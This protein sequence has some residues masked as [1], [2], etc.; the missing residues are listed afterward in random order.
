MIT[1]FEELI[2]AKWQDRFFAWLIDFVMVSVVVGIFSV[3]AHQFNYFMQAEWY[4]GTSAIFFVYWLIL[5]YSSGRSL[6]KRLMHLKT[7]KADGSNPTMIDSAVNSFGKSFL[8]PIDVILGLIFTDKKRQRIFN[9][10]SNTIVI[11]SNYP[12]PEEVPYKLD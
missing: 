8:L 3:A 9:R 12:E 1:N 2:L 6:G 11:K 10:L 5:E 4:A 7:V